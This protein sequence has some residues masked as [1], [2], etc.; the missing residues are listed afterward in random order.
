MIIKLIHGDITTFAGD[1]VVNAA[2]NHGLGGGGVDG[3]IHR[4]AGPRLFEA[5]KVL[6][7]HGGLRGHA[8]GFM[9]THDVR[10]PNGGAVPTP[11][12]DMPCKWIIHTA[13]PVWPKD[14]DEVRYVANDPMSSLAGAQL[15]V[16]ATSYRVG[17]AARRTLR[18]C[19]KMP[20]LAAVGMGLKSIAYPAISAGVYGC[21][22]DVCAEVALTFARDYAPWPIDV[23]FY[24]FGIGD[25]ELWESVAETHGI[26]VQC[27]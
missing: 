10:V 7:L 13:G 19:Y 15:K 26:A 11:A 12:F 5:C 16:G 20:M 21:P 25:R 8:S 6:P 1:A 27:L 4:A 18:D 2:N 9:P 23:T 17:D 14:P 24:L 3:A 22:M